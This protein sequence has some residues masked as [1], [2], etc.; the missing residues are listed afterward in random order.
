MLIPN[1]KLKIKRN[2]NR[3]EE[4]NENKLSLPSS[5]LIGSLI[6]IVIDNRASFEKVMK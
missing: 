1:P 6:K 2:K 4:R 3:N 5:T